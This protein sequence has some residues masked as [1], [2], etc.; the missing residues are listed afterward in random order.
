MIKS[1]YPLQKTLMCICL[2]VCF[3]GCASSNK[4]QSKN[5][6]ESDKYQLAMEFNNHGANYVNKDMLDEAI[7]QFKRALTIKPD[8][9]E[10]RNN[11]GVALCRQKMFD[12]AIAEFQL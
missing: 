1:K 10:V 2:V 7:V 3:F 9:A 8:L 4:Q 6:S 11:L 12:E 5:N